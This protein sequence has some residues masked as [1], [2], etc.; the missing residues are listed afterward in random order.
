MFAVPE[1]TVEWDQE[2]RSWFSLTVCVQLYRG[3]CTSQVTRTR[4]FSSLEK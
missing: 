4:H 1:M 3:N 2:K